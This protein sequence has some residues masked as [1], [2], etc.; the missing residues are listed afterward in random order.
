ME[1]QSLKL[2]RWIT[3]WPAFIFC[4]IAS[5]PQ[6]ETLETPDN[7]SITFTYNRFAEIENHCGF[8]MSSASELVPDDNRG[9]KMKKELFFLNGD[10]A[11]DSGGAPLM[12]FDNRD[13]P[14]NYF[15]YGAPMK[16]VSFWVMDVDPVRRVKNT[17]SV[18]A[19][20]EI[21]I[22]RRTSFSYK[23][24]DWSPGFHME[25][26]MSRLSILFEGIYVESKDNQG[27]LLMC[28]LGSST[29]PIT[30]QHVDSWEYDN[31][32]SY[33]YKK[34]SPLEQDDQ[35][36]LILRYPKTFTLTTRGISGEM[37]SLKQK[38]QLTYFDRVHIY[39]QLGCYSRYQFRSDE[40]LSKA[41]SQYPYPDNFVDEEIKMFKGDEYCEK[42]REFLWSEI[43][44][45]VSNWKHIGT[46]NDHSKLGPFALGWK[47][48]ATDGYLD[49]FRLMVQNLQCEPG[50]NQSEIKTA[51]VSAV[52]RVIRSSEYRQREEERTGLSSTTLSAEGVWHSSH[53]QLCMVGCLGLVGA[54]QTDAN[55]EFAYISL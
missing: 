47:I 20:L 19:E 27:Q 48:E 1:I 42:L 53:G 10:W 35:I 54:L 5:Y 14:S 52:F 50:N 16:L 2:Y 39:S 55:L 4:F 45:F 3:W 15:G 38:W 31:Q 30:S 22:T 17:V 26:G 11:Q 9:E 29:I 51:R 37:K 49:N 6:F 24:Y 41:C 12:P 32:H 34:Q 36:M 33:N 25:Q 21:G 7:P 40:L 44:R 46:N 23:P 43:F 13:Q 8:I 18:S 28:L